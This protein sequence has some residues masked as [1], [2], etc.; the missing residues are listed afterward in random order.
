MA[1]S[2]WFQA[3]YGGSLPDRHL[4][5]QPLL[6]NGRSGGSVPASIP[7]TAPRRSSP[8]GVSPLFGRVESNCPA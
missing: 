6:G 8:V 1:K 7:F 3:K 5:L 2:E 4:I